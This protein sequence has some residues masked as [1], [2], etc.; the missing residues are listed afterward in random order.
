MDKIEKALRKLSPAERKSIKAVLRKI[1]KREIEGLDIKKLKG[2]GDIFRVRK[3]NIRII[4]RVNNG[5]THILNISR[6]NEQTYD[7]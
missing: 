5:E 4:Y 7:L 3:G 2:R 1:I 6:R